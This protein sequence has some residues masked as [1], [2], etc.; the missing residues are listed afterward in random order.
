MNLLRKSVKCKTI[1][2]ITPAESAFGI[3]A[4]VIVL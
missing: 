1:Q 4:N 3:S 2:L